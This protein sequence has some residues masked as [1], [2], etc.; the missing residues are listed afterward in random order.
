MNE[1]MNRF[2]E[3][4]LLRPADAPPSRADMV[5]EC[6]LN[7]GVFRYQGRTGLLLRVAERPRPEEGWVSTPLLDPTR[8]GGIRILRIR[9]DDPDLKFTDPRIF[10]Y[11]GRG[12]L[13]TL[14][15]LR[16]AW[17]NDGVRFV[18]E[19]QP[20]LLGTGDHESFGIED[21]RVEFMA[22]RYWLTYSAVSAFGVG[23]SGIANG[24]APGH[25][26]S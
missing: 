6:L 21:C 23:A 17:S 4:P 11:K 26:R 13:T 18:V 19:P 9:K 1:L 10:S 16:L 22:G 24:L 2:P 7:P 3:N 20:T 25:P 5:V 15:H 8:D 14:S 12:Y